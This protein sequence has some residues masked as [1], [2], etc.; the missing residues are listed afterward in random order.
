MTLLRESVR[1]AVA[2]WLS[3][4]LCLAVCA[5]A[6]ARP[7]AVALGDRA[8]VEPSGRESWP[9]RR[10]SQPQAPWSAGLR[11]TM[12]EPGSG[13]VI[14]GRGAIAVEPGQAVRMILTGAAGATMLDA[15]VTHDPLARRRTPARRSSA[16]ETSWSRATC[17]SG[18]C[19]GGF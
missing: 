18:F 11:I 5:R 1:G 17:R 19:G 13:R 2:P 8:V 4:C 10:L 16:A 14:D 7:R 12:R 9:S 15:W 3:L 6:S